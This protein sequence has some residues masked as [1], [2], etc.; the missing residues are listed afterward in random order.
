MEQQDKQTI[1]R[2]IFAAVTSTVLGT[3]LLL[4]FPIISQFIFFLIVV[5][6]SLI[7][8]FDPINY[9]RTIVL[10]IYIL[11]GIFVLVPG[12]ILNTFLMR[13]S[14]NAYKIT[15]LILYLLLLVGIAAILSRSIYYQMNHI[16]IKA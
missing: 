3:V 8:R 1:S 5:P 15:S 6:I 11:G 10:G 2:T 13:R 7:L 4:G 12:V 14:S 9:S 16:N